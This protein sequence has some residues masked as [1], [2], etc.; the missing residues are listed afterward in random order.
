MVRSA[1]QVLFEGNSEVRTVS[2]S[3]PAGFRQK[4]PCGNFSA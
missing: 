1:G 4:N 2:R 3:S